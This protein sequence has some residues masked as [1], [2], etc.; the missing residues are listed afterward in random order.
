MSAKTL[1]QMWMRSCIL[2]MTHSRVPS[3][4]Y[5]DEHETFQICRALLWIMTAFWQIGRSLLRS[6]FL[7]WEYLCLITFF[8]CVHSFVTFCVPAFPLRKIWRSSWL[9]TSWLLLLI[10]WF[11]SCH[12][13]HSTVG[14]SQF[15]LWTD[16]SLYPYSWCLTEYQLYTCCF[17]VYFSSY[18]VFIF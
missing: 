11:D 2:A 4:A 12:P 6:L 9:I 18:Y 10:F 13:V 1:V 16:S 8:L 14:V 3:R 5:K 15:L 17:I 7:S